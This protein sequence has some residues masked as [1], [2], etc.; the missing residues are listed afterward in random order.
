[1]READRVVDRFADRLK[2]GGILIASIHSAPW[3][4][5]L[6]KQLPKR[7]PPSFSSLVKRYA[8]VPFEWGPLHFFGNSAT[9][10]EQDFPAIVLR[11]RLLWS[12][13][14]NSGFVQFAQPAGVNHDA[15]C[16]D[17]R[18]SQRNRE[19]PIVRLDHESILIKQR[20]K[21]CGEIAPSFFALVETFVEG[22]S[23]PIA[24]ES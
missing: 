13:M 16:F 22:G 1:M 9:G 11:D 14:L 2:R 15:I 8:Y 24:D 18:A 3:I 7:L 23:E 5:A 20:I 21:I 17:M 4:D 10:D 6:E 12:T 19:F